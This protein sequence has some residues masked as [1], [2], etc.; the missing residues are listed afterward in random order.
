MRLAVLLLAVTVLATPQSTAH[1]PGRVAFERTTAAPTGEL[2]RL[3]VYI[4]N[5]A[6]DALRA[7]IDVGL[8]P[9]TLRPGVPV[10]ADGTFDIADLAPG[11]Y[12]ISVG[13]YP[14]GFWPRSA[15]LNG[16]DVFDSEIRVGPATSALPPVVLTFTDRQTRLQGT[17]TATGAAPAA[18]YAVIALPAD[19]ALRS[20]SRRKKVARAEANG[21]YQFRNLPPGDYLVGVHAAL[22]VGG[23]NY[24]DPAF[25]DALIDTAVKVTI[26]EGEFKTLDLRA[27]SP[28]YH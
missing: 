5:S 10:A 17:L 18:S 23:G 8:A 28:Y 2:T 21:S 19:R 9:D 11:A 16:T 20:V 3:R 1:L 15:M 4:W 6:D 25:L 12:H 7:R 26:S 22:G 14:I 24:F 13:P 27:G